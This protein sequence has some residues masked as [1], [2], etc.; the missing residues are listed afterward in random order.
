MK[1]PHFELGMHFSS[2]EVLRLAVR[3]HAITQRRHVL[4]QP[5]MGSKVQFI[6]TSPYK[7]KIY[8]NKCQ[9]TDSYQIRTYQ[10][11][12][13]CQLTWEQK[14]LSADWIARRY[15]DEIRMNHSWECEAF[16]KKVV[17]D[18]GCQVNKSMCY[19]AK[20][21][22][23]KAI[24]GTHE[25]SYA[26]LWDYSNEL[27]RVLWLLYLQHTGLRATKKLVACHVTWSGGARFL[28]Q[29]SA[30]GYELV[31]DLTAKTCACKKWQLSGISCFHA[32][33]CL[34]SKGFNVAN[35]GVHRSYST[36][37]FRNVYKHIVE[38]INGK[39]EWIK[40]GFNKPLPPNVKPSIG[41]PKI[42]RNK[43][44]DIKAPPP[45]A[46]KLKRQKTSLRC[47]KCNQWGHN[48]RTCGRQFRLME[49]R[50][51]YCGFASL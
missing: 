35:F 49:A 2:A 30:G 33:A 10:N 6:C 48:K 42:G 24:N 50:L 19:R 45:D 46:T 32:V 40:T 39:E 25:E 34:N 37:M 7:W 47:S 28:V 8:A 20:V 1:D 22:A 26:M 36:N 5:N 11:K 23:L 27:R 43:K 41:R 21:I 51:L 13:T 29:T 4:R 9:K 18:L 17:N 15:M 3:S 12:H 14:Q 16:Q 38:P 31:V 44:N